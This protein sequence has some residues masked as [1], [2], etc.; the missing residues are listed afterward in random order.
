M[1]AGEMADVRQQL[2]Q[3][4]REVFTPAVIPGEG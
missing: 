2:P 3:E 4:L 1:C